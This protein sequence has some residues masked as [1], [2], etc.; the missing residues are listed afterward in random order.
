MTYTEPK[1]ELLLH[2]VDPLMDSFEAENSLRLWD[3]LNS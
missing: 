2:T 3:L 1:I